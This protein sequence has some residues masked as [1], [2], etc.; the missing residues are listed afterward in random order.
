MKRDW[1]NKPFQTLVTLGESTTA[2]GWA[3]CRQHSWPEL[4]AGQINLLQRTPLHLLNM[5]IGA[6]VISTHSPC[7]EASNK[8]AA[9]ERIDKHMIAHKPDLLV[10][11]YGL[12]DARGGTPVQLFCD[13]MQG[14]IDRI[15]KSIQPVILLPGPYFMTDFTAGGDE[16][17]HA[18]LSLFYTYNN[19]IKSLAEQADCLFADLLAS[20][21]DAPWLVNDDGV[22]ANDVGHRIV[23]NNMFEVLASNCSGIAAET[24]DMEKQIPFW[25]ED[26]S[27]TKDYD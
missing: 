11:A 20:Y 1:Q 7:Y 23:A 2:G 10:I 24:K 9:D 17:T 12:N 8:P 21:G 4:L 14:I 5:G 16:W 22:H 26:Q 27:L 6:N 15:R 18:D 19:S 3:S 13:A 25:R